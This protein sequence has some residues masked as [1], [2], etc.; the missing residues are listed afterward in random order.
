MLYKFSYLIFFTVNTNNYTV[1]VLRIFN[2]YAS[3]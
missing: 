2:T 3:C 1:D